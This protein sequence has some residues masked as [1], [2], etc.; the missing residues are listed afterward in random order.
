MARLRTNLVHW[1]KLKNTLADTLNIDPSH[2]RAFL[3]NAALDVE[4]RAE[5]ESLLT[6]EAD[7]GD[8]LSMPASGLTSD[9]FSTAA[10]MFVRRRIGAY[11]L[12]G[13][14]GAGGMG[15]VYLAER[16][17]G[18]F[19]QRVAIKL[20][21]RE[22][23][24]W[25][26]REK[27]DREKDILAAL[28]HPYVAAL[29][30]TGV[31]DDGVPYLVME[32]VDG[33]PVDQFCR[34]NAVD[35]L[36]RLKI[37]NKICESVAFAHHN[38]VVHRD[39]KPSNILVTKSGDPKLLDFG[40]SKILDGETQPADQPLT[41]A[42]AMTPEYASPEQI[43]GEIVTT[44]TDIYSLGV[45]LFKI[46]TGRLPFGGSG[47]SNGSLLKEITDGEPMA[48]SVAVKQNAQSAIRDP[49]LRGDL[50]NIVLK[51]IDKRPGARYQTVEQMSADIWRHIDGQPVLARSATLR[52]RAGKF[53][54]RN[55]IAVS[56]ASLVLVTII[57]GALIA[58]WQARVARDQAIAASEAQGL[59]ETETE[60]ANAERR[61]AEKVSSFMMKIV[62]Y[63]NPR[64]HA[65]GYRSAGE[66]RVID[67][68]ADMA[69]KIDTEFA[70]QPD[71]LAELHHHFADTYFSREEPALRD[72][73][74][75]HANR[76]LELRRSYY[77]DWH[78]LVAKDM[79]YVY[80]TQDHPRPEA[81][82]TML[83]DAIV[84]MRATNP[85]NLNLPFM[86][87][88]YYH[89]LSDDE[90]AEFH[91]MFLRYVP[92]IAA[93]DKYHAA[94]QL[95]DEMM[96]LLRHHFADE[97]EQIVYQKCNGMEL[98]FRVGKVGEAKDFYQ[99]C[100]QNEGLF[101]SAA[102]KALVRGRLETYRRMTGT[103]D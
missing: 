83:S 73:A 64:W 63:A 58:G 1:D 8:F 100:K 54:R 28:S 17:D 20:L 102:R 89:R 12:L 32:Y 96:G 93:A 21:R 43:N 76:A 66:A 45:L 6:A 80:W 48:P 16:R 27:F 77:G 56:A 34:D 99:T 7:A 98:K 30:D 22:F 4:E 5:I 101:T 86:L 74:R 51:A 71:V 18:K 37:F 40:I 47:K 15:A 29:L 85:E 65:E 69:S 67:A 10:D 68:L 26:I 11:E 87:E 79:V 52:Y 13:E 88:D 57:A 70:D 38:L 41:F 50:D 49:Q 103:I 59:A 90:Y 82:V 19:Q 95:L 75:A 9:F 42:G 24:T 61:K 23:D 81:T 92:V 62:S 78:E 44:A 36:G 72:K 33:V 31:T 46:L 91:E 97:H 2:R 39:L 14:L 94:D 60:K 35:L 3:D 53:V 84:M 25:A 55:R